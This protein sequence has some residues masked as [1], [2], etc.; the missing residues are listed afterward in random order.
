MDAPQALCLGHSQRVGTKP[1][2]MTAVTKRGNGRGS[3]VKHYHSEPGGPT[4]CSN[5]VPCTLML[6]DATAVSGLFS[7]LSAAV[8]RRTLLGK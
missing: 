2:R 1:S 6:L 7:C 3:T 5:P 8:K 4:A